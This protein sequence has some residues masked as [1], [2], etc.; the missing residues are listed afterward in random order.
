MRWTRKPLRGLLA[1]AG[2]VNRPSSV[3]A[4]WGYVLF[5]PVLMFLA[6]GN[7]ILREATFGQSMTDLHAHQL[8]TAIAMFL[9]GVSVF[10]LSR[11]LVPTS[12][13]QAALVGS[14]WLVLTLSFEFLF[15]R[16]LAGHS[17]SQLFQE[18]DLLSGRVWPLLLVWIA[19]LPLLAYKS[20]EPAN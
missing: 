9:F 14:I 17:W 7:G 2:G 20:G 15:G 10:A 1:G 18:Y 11:Y 8:S 5:W 3:R 13:K 19:F 4:F 6:I 16:Y 12:L